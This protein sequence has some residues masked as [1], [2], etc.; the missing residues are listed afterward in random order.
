MVKIIFDLY[1][2]PYLSLIEYAITHDNYL[3]RK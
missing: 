3:K 1:M 2:S